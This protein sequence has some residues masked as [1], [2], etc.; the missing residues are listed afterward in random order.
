M[1]GLLVYEDAISRNLQVFGTFAA[2]ERL[3]MVA[4]R[5]GADRQEMHEIIREHSMVA[6][7]AIQ[8]GEPNPL[9]DSLAADAVIAQF[10]APDEIRALM[11]ASAYVGDAPRR[12][13][14][15]ALEIKR[16]GLERA[17]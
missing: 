17:A 13:H 16:L 1:D 10:V 11:D 8:S 7:S 14:A 3:L 15:M 6:W 12:A 9:G 5:S 4:V 2:T